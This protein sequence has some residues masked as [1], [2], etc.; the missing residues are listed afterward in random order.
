[1]RGHVFLFVQEPPSTISLYGDPLEFV[2]S[3]FITI[4]F[5]FSPASLSFSTHIDWDG[6]LPYKIT[7]TVV[8]GGYNLGTRRRIP[9]R[10]KV[11]NS[12][13]EAFILSG[14]TQ[15]KIEIKYVEFIDL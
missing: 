1:M 7:C 15:F 11:R 13:P 12:K 9:R 3:R 2:C 4:P 5:P 8:T 14:H 10:C 6:S